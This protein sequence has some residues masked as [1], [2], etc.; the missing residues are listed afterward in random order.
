MKEKQDGR[1]MYIEANYLNK[2]RMCIYEI[3]VCLIN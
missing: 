3:Q 2:F 1:R